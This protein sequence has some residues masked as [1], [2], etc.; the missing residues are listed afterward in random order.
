MP[1]RTWLQKLKKVPWMMRLYGATSPHSTVNSS[2]ERW[3]LSTAGIRARASVAP[4][5]GKVKRTLASYGLGFCGQ[6]SLFNLNTVSSKTLKATSRLDSP[7]SSAIWKKQVTSARGDYLARRNAALLTAGNACSSSGKGRLDK[8]EWATPRASKLTGHSRDDFSVALPEQVKHWAT[9]KANDPE[10]RGNFDSTNPRNGLPGQVLKWPTPSESASHQGQNEAD[11]KRGQTLV[12]AARNQNWPTPTTPRPHDNENTAGMPMASQKQMD[13]ATAVNW[14]TP[15]GRDGR[16]GRA[17]EETMQRN[18][19][20]LN[21]VV[22]CGQQDQANPSTNGNRPG[23]LN[24]DWVEALMG[25]PPGWTVCNCSETP[26][27]QTPPNSPGELSLPA[28]PTKPF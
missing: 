25:Y 10:K 6:L 1:A 28:S 8:S 16:D 17:S 15:A 18:S 3:I 21:E 12:G 19:R 9:P 26:S 2:L 14:P 13:L 4:A 22:V 11:G 5:T 7:Q 24:P 20:P 27:S 23:Q